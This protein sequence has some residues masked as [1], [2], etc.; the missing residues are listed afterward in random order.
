[1]LDRIDIHIEVPAV[2]FRELRHDR[3]GPSSAEL[4][5]DVLDARLHQRERFG[6]QSAQLNGRMLH[7]Q[8]RQHCRLDAPSE[9]LLRA[10][11]NELG[12]SARAHD[13]V[14]RIARTIADLDASANIQSHHLAEAISYR[15]LDRSYWA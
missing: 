5:K 7:R 8:L 3:A 13:K 11:M 6:A 4:R 10:A 12:L 1:M 15:S 2:P 9:D 14:L